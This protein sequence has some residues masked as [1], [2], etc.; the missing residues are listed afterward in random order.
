VRQ[1]DL[2]AACGDG[3]APRVR[4]GARSGWLLLRAFN[5]EGSV[6]VAIAITLATIHE[7]EPFMGAAYWIPSFWVPALLVTHALVFMILLGTPS[8]RHD[9]IAQAVDRILSTKSR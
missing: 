2:I 7:A 8:S 9:A 3:R 6:D 5:I 4:A 1:P